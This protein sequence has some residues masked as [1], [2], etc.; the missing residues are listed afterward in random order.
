MTVEPVPGAKVSRVATLWSVVYHHD[1][2]NYS[3]ADPDLD[4][5]MEGLRRLLA[6]KKIIPVAA[7]PAPSPSPPPVS[8]TAVDILEEGMPEDLQLNWPEGDAGPEPVPN[9]LAGFMEADESPQDFRDRIMRLLQRF[10]MKEGTHGPVGSALAPLSD[11]EKMLLVPLIVANTQAGNW[12]GVSEH[13]K[14]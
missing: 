1:G 10:G 9:E 2:R 4:K 6:R 12:L 13:L 3:I 8:I 14:D 11:D 7:K 5:A